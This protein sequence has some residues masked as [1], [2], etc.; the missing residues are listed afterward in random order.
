MDRADRHA[1]T[2]VRADDLIWAGASDLAADAAV[3][4]AG[5]PGR[6][7]GKVDG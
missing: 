7:P 5:A 1:A 6:G 2:G 4:A 3:A